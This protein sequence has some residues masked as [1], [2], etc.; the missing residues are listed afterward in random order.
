[1]P[2][3]DVAARRVSMVQNFKRLKEA[4]QGGRLGHSNVSQYGHTEQVEAATKDECVCGLETDASG[5]ANP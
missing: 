5:G 1:M 2:P 4:G 3:K